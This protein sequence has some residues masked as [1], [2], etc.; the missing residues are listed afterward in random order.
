[1]LECSASRFPG[2]F[3]FASQGRRGNGHETETV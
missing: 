1:V 2:T 3:F